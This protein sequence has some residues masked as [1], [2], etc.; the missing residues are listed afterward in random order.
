M[1]RRFGHKELSLTEQFANRVYVGLNTT[2]EDVKQYIRFIEVH[3][4][5]ITKENIS[6]GI[7]VIPLPNL[8]QLVQLSR[9]W[10]PPEYV[11]EYWSTGCKIEFISEED[12]IVKRVQIEKSFYEAVVENISCMIQEVPSEYV[13]SLLQNLPKE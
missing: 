5:P 1:K 2:V 13:T 12:Y 10:K 7:A 8:T 6:N 3:P 4:P 11:L 9:F